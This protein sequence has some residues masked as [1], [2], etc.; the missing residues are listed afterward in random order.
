MRLQGSR[1]YS[2]GPLADVEIRWPFGCSRV[3]GKREA[4]VRR[5]SNGY[6]SAVEHDPIPWYPTRP[7]PIA[8]SLP[9]DAVDFLHDLLGPLN[10]RGNERLCS[11]TWL[12]IK[13]IFGRLQMT[14]H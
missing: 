11:W 5:A 8:A 2:H 13:E 12:G 6:S 7:K 4:I 1:G 14:R 9:V 3:T 10:G